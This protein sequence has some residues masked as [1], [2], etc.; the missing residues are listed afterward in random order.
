M[1]IYKR[2]WNKIQDIYIFCWNFAYKITKQEPLYEYTVC[3]WDF[4]VHLLVCITLWCYAACM[5]IITFILLCL[6]QAG[7]PCFILWVNLYR[8]FWFKHCAESN[9]ALLL[10]IRE[11]QNMRSMFIWLIIVWSLSFVKTIARL[12]VLKTPCLR[13]S[14]NL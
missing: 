6:N 7:F 2:L 13:T 10:L 9:C 1:W 11:A 4:F 8:L 5:F 3:I 12:V 14:I